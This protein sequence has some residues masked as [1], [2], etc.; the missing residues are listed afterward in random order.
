MLRKAPVRFLREE[1]IGQE[2]ALKSSVVDDE[3]DKV[4]RNLKVAVKQPIHAAYK[5]YYL[6][7]VSMSL[8]VGVL[9]ELELAMSLRKIDL[10]EIALEAFVDWLIK[11]NFLL[12]EDRE[13]FT[14][15]HTAKA[16]DEELENS[17]LLDTRIL[18]NWAVTLK[19]E[20]YKKAL[21][22]TRKFIKKASIRKWE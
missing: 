19:K 21:V 17:K 20:L 11:H 13:C 10:S 8:P 15:P 3:L 4:I 1:V 9:A 12:A 6:A 14:L 16:T 7:D 18:L 2:D 22:E 5:S